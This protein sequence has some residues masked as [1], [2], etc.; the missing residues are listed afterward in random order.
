MLWELTSAK[1][2]LGLRITLEMEV[3][4][5]AVAFDPDGANQPVSGKNCTIRCLLSRTI[6]LAG[7]RIGRRT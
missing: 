2:R 3:L 1:P 6:G 4:G 7:L 5:I